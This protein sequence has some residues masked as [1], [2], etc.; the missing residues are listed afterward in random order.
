MF[1][2]F[3]IRDRFGFESAGVDAGATIR[4]PVSSID[5]AKRAATA[6][7]PRPRSSQRSPGS[8]S[9]TAATSSGQRMETNAGGDPGGSEA[10][11]S[12]ERVG[13]AF[14]SSASDGLRF[15]SPSRSISETERGGS[16]S[17]SEGASGPRCSR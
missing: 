8:G 7:M 13:P 14:A 5:S 12:S 2:Y 10:F 16:S 6:P 1:E 4:V 3:E 15:V 17:C 11:D 9:Q